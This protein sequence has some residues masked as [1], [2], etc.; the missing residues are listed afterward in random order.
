M[1]ERRG[2]APYPHQSPMLT[3]RLRR[4]LCPALLLAGLFA[5]PAGAAQDPY[6]AGEVIVRYAAEAD[7]SA[8]A[9]AQR[10][11][12]A[13]APEAFAPRTRVLRIRDGESVAATVREL[14]RRPEVLDASPNHIAR[15]SFFP[16][17]PGFGDTPGGWAGVQWNLDGPAGV[18]ASAAWANL[19]GAGRDG[20]RGVTVAVLDTGVAYAN[21]GRFRRSPDL[22][23]ERMV[24][25]YDFVGRDPYP[26]DHNGHGTHVASTIGEVA[27][28]QLGLTGL[29]YGASIMPIRVLNQEGEGRSSSIASG[30]RYAASHGAD[31]INL[32]F[33]FE[34]WVSASGIPAVLDALRYARSRGTLVVGASGNEGAQRIPYPARAPEVL[35]VG[36]TTE[37]RCRAYYSNGGA[38]L[39][40][41]APGGGADADGAGCLEG[42]PPGRDIFQLTLDGS[43]ARFG[44]PEGYKGTSMAAPHVSAAAALVIASGV[45][46]RDPAPRAVERRLRSS[47]ADLGPAGYDERN[48]W[49]LLDAGA[50]TAPGG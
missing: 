14:E 13:G 27:N 26:N 9:A 36:G 21:R 32:S 20:G 35:S 16:N 38:G 22:S 23:A 6:P 5:A 42:Q 12:G 11:A 25:G 45:V 1:Q 15:A 8:R 44:I 2:R 24:R 28:N 49:G 43:I 4:V 37:H 29:A 41:V 31:V 18:N 47:A 17:D 39:D 46:G 33:E 50:A 40:L 30:I 34:S 48:G 7:R 3:S 10:A 19:I